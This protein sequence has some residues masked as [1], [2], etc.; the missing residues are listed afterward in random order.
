MH[1]KMHG[2][3][4]RVL[5]MQYMHNYHSHIRVS[6]RKKQC[7]LYPSV[8]KTYNKSNK[9]K[10]YNFNIS[11]DEAIKIVFNSL[12]T[13]QRIRNVLILRMF[14]THVYLYALLKFP[15]HTFLVF[16]SKRWYHEPRAGRDRDWQFVSIH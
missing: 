5:Y 15:D 13:I 16:V 6:I 1:Q 8:R 10:A 2:I 3:N 4:T 9:Q 7:F 12:S 11:F 14:H